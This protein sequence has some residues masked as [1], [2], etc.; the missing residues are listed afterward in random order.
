MTAKLTLGRRG[1]GVVGV[2]GKEANG[3]SH[4]LQLVRCGGIVRC[5]RAVRSPLVAVR[6]PHHDYHL[7]HVVLGAF[8]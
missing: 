7:P 6:R 5:C 8:L 2:H 4:V 3:C 1:R